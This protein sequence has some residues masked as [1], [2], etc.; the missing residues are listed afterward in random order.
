M[1]KVKTF[2]NP[3]TSKPTSFSSLVRVF[4]NNYELIFQM[5]KRDVTARYKGSVFGFAWSFIN[6]IIMLLIYTIVF[7]IIFK[8]RWGID[9][10]ESN[11]QF[12]LIL[13]VGL[14]I[15]NMFSE[16]LNRSSGLILN[17]INFVKKVIFP[18][19]I[20]PI[21]TSGSALFHAVINIIVLMVVFIVFN[22]YIH[23]SV[24]YL[25]IIFIP[26]VFMSLGFSWMIASLGVFLRD[27]GQVIGLLTTVLMFLSPVFYPISAV[28]YQ[29][30]KIIMA[31]PLTFIIEQSRAVII[32]GQHPSWTGLALYLLFST[33][34]MWFGYV[35]FQK[36]R[37][38][39]S[40][41]I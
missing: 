29:L 24:L 11:S 38:G 25:P 6:P 40:D 27:L 9:E 3:H 22:G 2:I 35:C 16:V 13:F 5:M 32:W 1:N 18:I 39:F 33:I 23:I 31:N 34:V 30:Q 26:F 37:K 36:T 14:I 17:N 8:V 10:I 7:S 12:A 4:I 28:P 21:I 19:E 41:V 20:L 15:L